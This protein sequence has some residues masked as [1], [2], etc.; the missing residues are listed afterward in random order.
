M[1]NE[2]P[3]RRLGCLTIGQ[4]PTSYRESMSYE[5]QVLWL[6]NI[7]E[8]D[9]TPAL[10]EVIEAVNNIDVNFEE[11]N[12]KIALIQEQL[13]LIENDY[14][15]LSNKVDTNTQNIINLDN[16][17]TN[18]IY[19]VDSNLKNLIN[20]NFNTLK[21]YVDYNDNIL[22]NKIDNISTT[23]IMAYN[24]TNGL[25]EPLQKVLNDIA[26]LSNTDGLTATEFDS[27][28]LTA[29]AFD[30][31]QITAKEFDSQGKTILV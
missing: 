15:Q 8:K 2:L 4:L 5:E 17:F 7:I 27:L 3:N 18:L 10:N 29:T 22:N 30:A 6:C 1:I 14:N 31:Y 25:L 28:D 9:I 23:G 26:Q 11:I 24:P 20:T 19:E 16:K 12:H 13:L 21:D